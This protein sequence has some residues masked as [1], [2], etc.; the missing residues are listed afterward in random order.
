MI[1]NELSDEND[2]PPI[3]G[4]WKNVYTLVVIS[5]VVSIVLFYAFT[6]YFS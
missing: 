3:L 5:L 4:T 1:N 6:L 2:V